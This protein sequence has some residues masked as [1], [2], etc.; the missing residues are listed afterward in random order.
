MFE[1]IRE[2]NILN[3]IKMSCHL[4]S[5]LTVSPQSPIFSKLVKFFKDVDFSK[6]C[7]LTILNFWIFFSLKV[8]REKIVM[9]VSSKLPVFQMRKVS[10]VEMK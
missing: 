3:N 7:T 2:I 10:S 8:M 9:S 4:N 6:N 1:K 5:V